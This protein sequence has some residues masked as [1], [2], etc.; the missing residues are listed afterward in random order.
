MK[1]RT[2]L[3]A[4][5]LLAG[6]SLAITAVARPAAVDVPQTKERVREVEQAVEAWRLAWELGEADTYLRFYDPAFRGR[7]ASR[8]QWEKERRA[9]LGQRKIAVAVDKMQVRLVSQ[10]EAEVRF[11]QR[12]TSAGHQDTGDKRLHMRRIGGAWKITR[13]DFRRAA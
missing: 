9:R 6:S 3:G 13:E 10:S 4:L 8:K 2:M 11:R 12:Y 7:A 5:A 1:K